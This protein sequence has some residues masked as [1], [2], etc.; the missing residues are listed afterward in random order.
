MDQYDLL[1]S[2]LKVD[3]QKNSKRITAKKIKSSSKSPMPIRWD[4]ISQ[5]T[6]DVR[7][8]FE[9]FN[10]LTRMSPSTV[11][12]HK[13]EML[14]KFSRHK[15][16]SQ[17]YNRSSKSQ[18]MQEAS[19]QLQ[20]D[21]DISPILNKHGN[22]QNTYASEIREEDKIQIQDARSNRLVTHGKVEIW[23]AS[24]SIKYV[25][26]Q[27]SILNETTFEN[28]FDRSA[29][30]HSIKRSA[31]SRER[32]IFK[33]LTTFS[34]AKNLSLEQKRKRGLRL[35][36]NNQRKASEGLLMYHDSDASVRKHEISNT[37]NPILEQIKE[38]RHFFG[39]ERSLPNIAPL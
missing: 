39:Q 29:S 17:E 18:H 19:H 36:E 22:R 20:S 16:R 38:K 27:R 12:N 24:P 8:E 6:S 10:E 30:T 37:K 32:D 26:T 31:G 13:K 15:D 23:K 21:L 4:Q 1:V 2:N 9:L 14:Q 33:P 35:A 25:E 11:K 28:P 7:H 3:I 5:N 34:E